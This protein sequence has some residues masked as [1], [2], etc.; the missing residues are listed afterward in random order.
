MENHHI[1]PHQNAIDLAADLSCN[2]G[3]HSSYPTEDLH[4][5]APLSPTK[6]APP[7]RNVLLLI[8]DDLGR[9][10]GCYGSRVCETPHIDQL[11]TE[12]TRFTRGFAST[13][14]C[15]GSRSTI[16]TGLHT[17]QNGQYGLAHDKYHFM[18]FDNVDTIP[19]LMNDHGYLTGIIGKVH[20]GPDAVYPWQVRQETWSQTRDVARISDRCVDFFERAKAENKSFFLTVG[21]IDPH[22]DLT[23]DGW[24]NEGPFDKRVQKRTYSPDEVEV[25]E[26]LTDLPETRRE[27]ANYYESI[28]RMDQG[29]GMILDGLENSGL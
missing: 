10:V 16:Y 29:V 7:T 8:A 2:S 23:R 17:H 22:R 1:S 13:A 28:S 11:A 26:F 6:M 21:F 20:V 27:F 15:S 9:Q 18:T 25:P 24:G 3:F 19:K 5:Q 12:G 14:S 4:N